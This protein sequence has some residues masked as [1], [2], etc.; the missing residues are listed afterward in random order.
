MRTGGGRQVIRV[1]RRPG[2]IA[3]GL[4]SIDGTVLP[5]R[6]G[7][8]GITRM[9]RE[10]DGA[11]PAGRLDLLALYYRADRMRR[12][13]PWG[14]LRP[15]RRDMGWCDDAGRGQYNREVALPFAGSHEML[16]REDHVYDLVG[17]LDWNYCRRSL[18]RGSAIFLHVPRAT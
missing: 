13:L 18:G 15:L 6:L 9:K 2:T 10:G 14:A 1:R 16:F 7:R 8:S 4:L 11:T 5:C 3:E 17:V 12:P